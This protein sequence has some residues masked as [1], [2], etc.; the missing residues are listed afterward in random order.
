MIFGTLP[1]TRRRK[2]LSKRDLGLGSQVY[3]SIPKKLFQKFRLHQSHWGRT[4]S[5]MEGTNEMNN[6]TTTDYSE[7]KITVSSDPCCYGSDYTAVEAAAITARLVRGIEAQ[8]PGIEARVCLVIETDEVSGPD[9]D[10]CEVISFW[11]Q[12]NWTSAL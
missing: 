9:S 8:F 11:I 3:T 12:N 10:I 2:P 5:A 1:D 4:V 6:V 7:Y